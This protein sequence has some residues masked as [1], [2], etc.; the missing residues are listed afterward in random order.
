M[1]YDLE[2]YKNIVHARGCYPA[3]LGPGERY[4]RCCERTEIRNL[5]GRLDTTHNFGKSNIIDITE[6]CSLIALF[7]MFIAYESLIL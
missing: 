3:T 1:D 5:S 4:S 6:C 7:N 2:T